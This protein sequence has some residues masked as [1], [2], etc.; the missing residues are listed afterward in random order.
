MIEVYLRSSEKLP[1]CNGGKIVNYV[2]IKSQ[3]NLKV[4]FTFFKQL[5]FA[6]IVYCVSRRRIVPKGLSVT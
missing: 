4:I 3:S 6:Y 1:M 2:R 5:C